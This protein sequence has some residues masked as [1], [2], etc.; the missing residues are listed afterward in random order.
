[1]SVELLSAI[2]SVLS[3]L[4][5]VFSNFFVSKVKID[6]IKLQ[7]GD[8]KQSRRLTYYQHKMDIII[9]SYFKAHESAY[10]G[11]HV[12]LLEAHMLSVDDAEMQTLAD[13]EIKTPE[14]A[15]AAIRRMARL[16]NQ[17]LDK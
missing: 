14:K 17:Q 8:E 13:A 2:V 9:A 16:I 5:I 7:Q 1:M 15:R 10:M 6:E 12:E 3:L 11:Y 4:A